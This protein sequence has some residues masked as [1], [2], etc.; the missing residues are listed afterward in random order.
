[1]SAA[2]ELVLNVADHARAGAT[3]FASLSRDGS[4]LSLFVSDC[5]IGIERSVR[6]NPDFAGR[7]TDTAGAI[8]LALQRA[9]GTESAPSRS[10]T[11]LPSVS[12]F[13]Q[14]SRGEFAVVTGGI[15]WL[16]RVGAGGAT[17]SMVESVDPWEGTI[18]A[19]RIP[20]P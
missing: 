10:R 9:I 3:G 19:L 1:A 8:A 5:G 14:S 15:S 13:C 4:A 6:E 7:L 16:R 11:G 20:A 12:E 2:R 17:P 18:V